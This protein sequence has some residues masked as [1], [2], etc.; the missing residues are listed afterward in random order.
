MKAMKETMVETKFG[1]RETEIRRRQGWGAEDG[2]GK[3]GENWKRQET[4]G[5]LEE[6]GRGGR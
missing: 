5:K 4:G 2:V 6:T 3:R 1:Q